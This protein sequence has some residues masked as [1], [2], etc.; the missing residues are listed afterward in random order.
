MRKAG[1]KGGGYR[2]GLRSHSCPDVTKA[3]R[4]GGGGLGQ[5][6]GTGKR[7]KWMWHALVPVLWLLLCPVLPEIDQRDPVIWGWVQDT[8]VERSH[9][10]DAST[11]ADENSLEYDPRDRAPWLRTQARVGHG[12]RQGQRERDKQRD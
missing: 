5:F 1:R 3:W 11:L 10:R 2:V 9:C 7:R 4:M 12:E 6:C 8:A